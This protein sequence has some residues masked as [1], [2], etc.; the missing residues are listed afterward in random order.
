MPHV[1]TDRA[2]LRCD[3]MKY[4]VTGGARPAALQDPLS[5]CW[6][7]RVRQRKE[8]R[9]KRSGADQ[10][11][12]VCRSVRRGLQH[13]EGFNDLFLA[14]LSEGGR[15][16]RLS[17]N[18]DP[19]T[20]L[21]KRVA[22]PARLGREATRCFT[23]SFRTFQMNCERSVRPLVPAAPSRAGWATRGFRQRKGKRIGRIKADQRGSVCSSAA[24]CGDPP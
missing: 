20:D 8:K 21:S 24:I 12:S 16:R 1:P 7:E 4:C 14:K 6:L 9:I 15:E 11:G 19:P 22:Q 18:Q 5:E 17:R 10:D 3:S 13:D 2:R 23:L